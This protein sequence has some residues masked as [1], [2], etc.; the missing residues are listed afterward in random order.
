MDHKYSNCSFCGG[1][2]SE[3]KV[4]V[5]YRSGE[6]LIIFENVPAGVC[7]QC[8]ER[9]Y[10]AKVVKALELMSQD[11]SLTDKIISIPVKLYPES[12]AV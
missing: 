12:M 9:Y 3:R 8:G 5:D 4:R 2:V 10:T 6:T 7:S 11:K 1:K